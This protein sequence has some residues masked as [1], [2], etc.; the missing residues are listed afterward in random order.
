M[1]DGH[2]LGGIG[3]DMYYGGHAH[4]TPYIIYSLHTYEE[5]GAAGKWLRSH[6]FDQ[7]LLQLRVKLCW[8]HLRDYVLHICFIWQQA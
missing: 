3:E 5:I 2:S 6:S 1:I 4:C 7:S 8:L